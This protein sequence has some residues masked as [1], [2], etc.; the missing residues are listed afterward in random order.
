M[1]LKPDRV[2]VRPDHRHRRP[3]ARRGRARKSERQFRLLVETI[4]A[5]VWCGNPEGELDYLNQR[6][7]EYLGHTAREPGGWAVA[8]TRPSRSARRDRATLAAF[9]HNGLVLR[10]CLPDSGAR[11]VSIDGFSPLESL[12]MT[13]TVGSLIGMAWSSTSTTESGPRSELRRAYDSFAD[14]QRLSKT[15]SFITDLVG[16]D[17][18]WSEEAFRIFE[19]EPGDESHGAA[20]SRHHSPR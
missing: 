15:G 19:F 6:A 5:L 2:L 8:R 12:S 9:G 14:A 10:R 1:T 20:N 17:H 16:D 4:P 7:V 13:R 3:K 18:N 11:T